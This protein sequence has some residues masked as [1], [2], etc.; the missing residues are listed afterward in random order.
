[1]ELLRQQ[2]ADSIL[3]EVFAKCPQAQVVAKTMTMAKACR[4]FS[5][6]GDVASINLQLACV[7]IITSACAGWKTA[8]GTQWSCS[9]VT[10][11]SMDWL[12]CG[13]LAKS[14]TTLLYPGAGVAS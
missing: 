10:A 13:L 3:T 2:E 11:Y 4:V 14:V 5:A 1:M 9:G 6:Y 8:F 12:K 7:E